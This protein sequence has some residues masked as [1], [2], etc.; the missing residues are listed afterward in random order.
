[1]FVKRTYII[2]ISYLHNNSM[3]NIL[4]NVFAN[5]NSRACKSVDLIIGKMIR[6]ISCI[7]LFFICDIFC[8][9]YEN[10]MRMYEWRNGCSMFMNVLFNVYNINLRVSLFWCVLYIDFRL[11]LYYSDKRKSFSLICSKE[12][13]ILWSHNNA[14]LFFS[15]IIISCVSS[16]Y[17]KS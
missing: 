2:H 6:I 1:M 5:E 7:K 3:C 15:L 16:R 8:E 4:I 12:S 11:F 13:K 17:Q 14:R 10:E 9:W